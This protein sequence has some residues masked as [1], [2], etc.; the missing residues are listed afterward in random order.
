ME[1]RAVVTRIDVVAIGSIV[2]ATAH[3]LPD[4]AGTLGG[5]LAIVWYLTQIIESRTFYHLKK[6]LRKKQEIEDDGVP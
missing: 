5:L 6:R 3:I 1:V 2:G 4:I